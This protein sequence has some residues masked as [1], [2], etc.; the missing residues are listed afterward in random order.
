MRI[1][2]LKD[3]LFKERLEKGGESWPF[4]PQL[5][6]NAGSAVGHNPVLYLFTAESSL[7]F[8][9]QGA[10]LE[11]QVASLLVCFVYPV[12]PNGALWTG[13]HLLCNEQIS[14]CF[15]GS[16]LC[17]WR[18]AQNG[19]WILET[20]KDDDLNELKKTLI[21]SENNGIIVE[22]KDENNDIGIST[23]KWVG[24]YEYNDLNEWI[25]WLWAV[26]NMEMNR[27]RY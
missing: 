18:N 17:A 27:V 16:R 19:L 25:G 11:T 22:L 12:L 6:T 3:A 5:W 13:R 14:A 8:W 2:R 10:T 15:C 24:C 23:N 26:Q 1:P 20:I 7:A 4:L 21:L 9:L